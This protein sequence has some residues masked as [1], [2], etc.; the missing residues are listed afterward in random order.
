MRRVP[1]GMTLYWTDDHDMSDNS[2]ALVTLDAGTG[3]STGVTGRFESHSYRCVTVAR[4]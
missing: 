4:D 1:T 3:P 2:S